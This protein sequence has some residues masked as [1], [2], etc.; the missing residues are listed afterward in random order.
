MAAVKVTPLIEVA[1]EAYQL[2]PRGFPGNFI[3]G[4]LISKHVEPYLLQKIKRG[5]SALEVY[6]FKVN[7]FDFLEKLWLDMFRD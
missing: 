4:Q 6:Y 7:T 5:I 3:K 1:L 2:A